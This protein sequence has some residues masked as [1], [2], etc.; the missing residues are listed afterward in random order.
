[1]KKLVLAALFALGAAPALADVSV[2]DSWVRATVPQQKA[3]GAFMQL[4]SDVPARLVAASSPLAGVVEIH[5]MRME[6]DVMKMG[7]VP[8]LE[9]PA[10]Q[11]VKLTPGGYHVMLMD[12]KQQVKEGDQVPL[13]LIVENKDGRRQ[14]LDLTLPVRPLN[15]LMKMPHGKH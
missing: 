11:T 7:P 3:T 5:E 1:M 8:A 15:A 2:S 6:K 13:T 14:S 4:K 12:L 10:G 9:L